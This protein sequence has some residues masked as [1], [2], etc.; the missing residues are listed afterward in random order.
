MTK[1]ELWSSNAFTLSCIYRR[2]VVPWWFAGDL[3]TVPLAPAPS[4]PASY[5]PYVL[6]KFKRNKLGYTAVSK[7]GSYDI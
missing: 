3:A 5:C 4:T 6:Y 7:P 2:V 1:P